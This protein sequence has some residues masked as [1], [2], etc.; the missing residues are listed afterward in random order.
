LDSELTIETETA[1]SIPR[2]GWP[3]VLIAAGFGILYAYVLWQAI[4]D[5]IQLPGQFGSV[6]PW[7][8]L[9]LDIVV[10]LAAFVVAFL[11]GRRRSLGARAL[12]F[13]VGLTVVAVSTVSSIAFFYTH[14]FLA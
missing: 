8:L 10:P 14:Y 2:Y 7:W 4:E 1:T 5:L 9:V 6:T 11:L 13:L 12:L 3:S